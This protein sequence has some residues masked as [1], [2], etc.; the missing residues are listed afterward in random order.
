M[1]L[2]YLRV[3]SAYLTKQAITK[4]RQTYN[5]PK[6]HLQEPN[7]DTTQVDAPNPY[8]HWVW[9]DADG[10]H[11]SNAHTEVGRKEARRRA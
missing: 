11:H 1:I 2:R 5:K 10:E 4:T 7:Q 6:P 9:G 8:H 3:T